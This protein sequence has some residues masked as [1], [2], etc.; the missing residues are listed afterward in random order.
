MADNRQTITLVGMNQRKVTMKPDGTTV[1]YDKDFAEYYDA[2]ATQ[3]IVDRE[4]IGRLCRSPI[5]GH[6]AGDKFVEITY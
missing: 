4:D 5:T 3:P 6:P 1:I 2:E